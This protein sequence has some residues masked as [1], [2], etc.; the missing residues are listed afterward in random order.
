M[1]FLSDL[2]HES[3]AH[4]HTSCAEQAGIDDNNRHQASECAVSIRR[5]A[6]LG[7]PGHRDEDAQGSTL[8][9][10]D[11]HAR[12][13]PARAPPSPSAILGPPR[14]RRGT[15]NF[16]ILEA[17]SPKEQREHP[18]DEGV[19]NEGVVHFYLEL[20]MKLFAI[21]K[22]K[23]ATDNRYRGP[24]TRGGG[25]T[26]ESGQPWPHLLS[27]HLEYGVPGLRRSS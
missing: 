4:G 11:R 8:R 16:T 22:P 9:S 10:W 7:P 6:I 21:S 26:R 12:P 5:P 19:V 23:E 27:S 2:I 20:N 3:A 17:T 25:G 15:I 1:S 13:R 18:E 14:V 24:D